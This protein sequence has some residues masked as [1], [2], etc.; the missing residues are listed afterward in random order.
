MVV[1]SSFP[2]ISKPCKCQMPTTKTPFKNKCGVHSMKS[3]PPQYIISSITIFLLAILFKFFEARK[4]KVC[5]ML[6]SILH[7][8][9]W[10]LAPSFLSNFSPSSHR[11]DSPLFNTGRLLSQFLRLL[12]TA[13]VITSYPVQQRGSSIPWRWVNAIGAEIWTGSIVTRG[14]RGDEG[15]SSDAGAKEFR[16]SV[17]SGPR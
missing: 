6:P 14:I 9:H 2:G 1:L 13:I 4:A 10:L 15:G 5:H 11:T 17:G 3:I 8:I 12:W 16:S 7:R